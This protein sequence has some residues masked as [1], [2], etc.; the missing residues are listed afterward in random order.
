[1]IGNPPKRQLLD[2]P[3]IR[4]YSSQPKSQQEI[5]RLPERKR[6]TIA[7]GL[8]CSGGVV[9]AADTEES[10][11]YPGDIKASGSKIANISSPACGALAISGSGTAGYLD[12]IAEELCKSFI[13]EGQPDGPYTE[14]TELTSFDQ[15]HS[16]FRRILDDF[17]TKHVLLPYERKEK[18]FNLIIGAT[19]AGNRQLWSSEQTTLKSSIM[20]PVAVGAGC[21]YAFHFMAGRYDP[22]MS[23]EQTALFAAYVVYCVKNT[24]VGC[25]KYT[26]IACLNGWSLKVVPGWRTKEIEKHF[27]QYSYLEHNLVDYIIGREPKNETQ[28][29][30]QFVEVLD[31]IRKSIST[32]ITNTPTTTFDWDVWK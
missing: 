12:S 16:N 11:G 28:L 29:K 21:H 25:G 13:E 24:I 5:K 10:A 14:P 26:E 8:T 22:L 9:I 7:I 20:R 4:P 17:Y 2:R 31:S 27:E 30:Q 18:H 15:T 19:R 32:D 23:L 6:M 3:R 1:L